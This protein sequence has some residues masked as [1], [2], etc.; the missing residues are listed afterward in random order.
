VVTEII[1]PKAKGEGTE[2]KNITKL[3]SLFLKV[4]EDINELENISHI[5]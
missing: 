1:G 3:K 5:K 4:I 2:L